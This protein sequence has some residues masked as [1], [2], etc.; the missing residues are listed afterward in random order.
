LGQ[1]SGQ[2]INPLNSAVVV[3]VTSEHLQ[4]GLETT[5]AEQ[6]NG[7]LAQRARLSHGLTF[8]DHPVGE[9]NAPR[10]RR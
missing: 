5:R 1:L 8:P 6:L 7:L 2:P 10:I 3:R 9:V 4:V